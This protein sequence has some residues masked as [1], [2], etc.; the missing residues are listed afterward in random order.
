MDD[1]AI[2]GVDPEELILKARGGDR[3]ALYLLLFSPWLTQLLDEVSGKTSWDFNVD[4]EAVRDFVFERVRLKIR[5]LKNPHNLPWC[6][7]FAGWCK[8]IA[9]NHARNLIRHRG[10]VERHWDGVSHEHTQSIRNGQ[11]ITALHAPT[12]SQEDEIEQKERDALQAKLH[13]TVQKVFPSLKPEDKK[14]ISMWSDGKKLRELSAETGMPISTVNNRLKKI[15]KAFVKEITEVV[16][17]EIGKTE[18][19]EVRVRQLLGAC[20]DGLRELIGN[21]L[22][23]RGYAVTPRAQAHGP[24]STT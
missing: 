10:V 15:L 4:G 11:R 3:N 18:T 6:E 17:K 20:G 1:P 9:E 21:S 12:V 14:L 5:K 16:V 2:Y 8:K 19:E 24:G 23:G 13:R 7:C 22:R